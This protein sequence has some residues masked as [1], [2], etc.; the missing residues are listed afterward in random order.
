MTALIWFYQGREYLQL[1]LKHLKSLINLILEKI[2]NFLCKG[3]VLFSC[4][5]HFLAK[6]QTLEG[7]VP[8]FGS[9]LFETKA[10][11]FQKLPS[12]RLSESALHKS[13]K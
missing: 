6:D 2:R 10:R 11:F 13:Q 4:Q 3:R 7:N 8:V 12:P 5:A 1:H 9:L